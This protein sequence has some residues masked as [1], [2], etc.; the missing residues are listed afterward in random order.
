MMYVTLY[1]Y[2]IEDVIARPGVAAAVILLGGDTP[3]PFT[4]T[5][6]F[7][8][9]ERVR[10]LLPSPIL[11]TSDEGNYTDDDLRVLL[12]VAEETVISLRDTLGIHK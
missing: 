12:R 5:R 7:K 2:V 11:T 8:A 9:G 10:I 3:R 4:P 1:G 6:D